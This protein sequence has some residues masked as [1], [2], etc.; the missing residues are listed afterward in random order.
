MSCSACTMPD[1]A[2]RG[3]PKQGW[4]GQRGNRKN[5]NRT[6]ATPSRSARQLDESVRELRFIREL[7]RFGGTVDYKTGLPY[8]RVII[9]VVLGFSHCSSRK[10]AT[11]TRRRYGSATPPWSRPSAGYQQV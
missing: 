9:K 11:P 10:S 3:E 7:F 4:R 1:N 8:I 2:A 5:P 6:T